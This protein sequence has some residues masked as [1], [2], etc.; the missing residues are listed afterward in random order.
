MDEQPSFSIREEAEEVVLVEEAEEEVEVVDFK[1]K[2]VENIIM[3]RQQH[4]SF[5]I[6]FSHF[7][8]SYVT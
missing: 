7:K 8:D 3:V 6:S 2:E 4:T 5:T 1:A